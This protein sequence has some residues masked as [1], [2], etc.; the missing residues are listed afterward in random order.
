VQIKSALATTNL[1]PREYAENLVEVLDRNRKAHQEFA[2]LFG[3]KA[4]KA[5][6]QYAKTRSVADPNL[7]VKAESEL[8]AANDLPAVPK[9]QAVPVTKSTK[10]VD[11][12]GIVKSF[13]ASHPG[14]TVIFKSP[15]DPIYVSIASAEPIT[16]TSHG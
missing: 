13:R 6:L 9:L 4:T 8:L 14:I 11:A 5:I 7:A 1:T 16:K 3:T 2:G 10:S 15:H 12:D